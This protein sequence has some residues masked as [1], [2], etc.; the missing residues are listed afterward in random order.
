MGH[1]TICSP[2]TMP[3][4][5]TTLHR[6]SQ[7]TLPYQGDA[8]LLLVRAR[9]M[10]EPVATAGGSVAHTEVDPRGSAR[11]APGADDAEH[12]SGH[13]RPFA[14]TDDWGIGYG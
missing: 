10:A 7:R 11:I 6:P 5:P 9:S 12:R 14:R 3:A 1:D 2:L 4:H 8:L 13:A